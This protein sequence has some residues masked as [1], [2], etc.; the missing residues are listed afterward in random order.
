MRMLTAVF[1]NI[2]MTTTIAVLVLVSIIGSIAAVSG[3]IYLNLHARSMADSTLQQQTNLAVAATI[4]ER[5]ISG[6]V[7]NWT[8]E[9]TM[10]AFQSWAVPP[11]YDTEIIDSVTRVTQQDATI[12]V[13]DSAT[14]VLVGKTTSIAAPDGT[15]VADLTLDASSPVFASLMAGEPFMGQLPINGVDYFGALQPIEKMSGEV[16]G[17]IFVGTPMAAIEAAAN[18]V[19]GLILMVGGAV[20]VALGLVGFVLSNVI[21]RP[22]P[23]LAHSMETI[24]E[25]HYDIDVPYTGLGNEVGG[26]A[27]AVEV[28][29]QN[30]LRVSQMTEAEAARI[31]ADQENRQQMMSE[32]QSA[33]GAV[34][35]AAVAGDFSKQVSVEFPDPELNAL[36]GSVNN[37]VSTFNRGVTEIGQVLGAMA[38]TDLTQ[39]MHGDYEGA[40][41]TLK[42]DI[43]AVADK[44][45]EVIG[46]LRHTSGSLKTATGEILSGA[47]DL[48]ERTT[49]QAA[50][51]EETSAAMEQL[52]ST[53]MQNAQ[54]AKEA[55]ANAMQV[56][57]TAE[58]GGQVMD[59]ATSAM[60]RITQS[61]AKISNIIGMI[62]DIAFQTNLLALNASVEAARAGDA[63]KGFAVVAVEVRRLAQSAA[64]A[65]SDVKALI[66]QSANEVR[67]GSKLVGDAA[68][69]LKSML[70][71]ARGNNGLLES[72]A[73]D[74]REQASAIEE[75]STAVRTMDE[76]TQ[77]NAAL[78][79]ETNAAI[80]QTEA[81]ATELDRI[82]EVFRITQQEAPVR[83]ARAPTPPASAA[84]GLQHRLASA[85]A[86]LK[87]HGN[88]A[89][90]ADWDEF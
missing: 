87:S 31:I 52:A 9:G 83:V 1:G 62:D 70:D 18:G 11:F 8:P 84:R 50:T 20:V 38:D 4:L 74:S 71:A 86:N 90:A 28:F 63:G 60:E 59:A 68:G 75:V 10:D 33:F 29:R 72:I 15:R 25:G 43:N 46:Q 41:A 45:T 80:E 3:A 5:R 64:S 39:R 40:F 54:R 69:K 37:L 67:T 65:S 19:L 66:E 77:H 22:I 12:Y 81:Q 55:S 2:R 79:E 48:S 57:K 35:D 21:T 47:N 85:S 76:M 56:T 23:K 14:Q 58:E 26:M 13:L 27:R 34:V 36:A 51:I 17:A 42:S 73:N 16:M 89:I 78:V 44:L 88:A 7:L 6:S 82:V 61:S 49:K 32:L 30:G 24:A 53:V